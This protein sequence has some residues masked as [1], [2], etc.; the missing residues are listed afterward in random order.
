MNS[1]PPSA[2][3]GGPVRMALQGLANTGDPRAGGG[4]QLTTFQ[5][6]SGWR[7]AVP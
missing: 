5:E 6:P 2:T 7:Q 4:Y 1:R 3:D